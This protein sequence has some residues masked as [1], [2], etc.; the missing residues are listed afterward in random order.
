MRFIIE[1]TGWTVSEI[2]E[3]QGLGFVAILKKA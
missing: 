2:V 3:S 1:K